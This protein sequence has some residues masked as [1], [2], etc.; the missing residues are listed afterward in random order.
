MIWFTS[1]QHFGHANIIKFCQR[2][3][4]STEEMREKLI[5]NFNSKVGKYD[6]TYHLGDM[7]W[8]KLQVDDCVNILKQLNGKHYY[9]LGN[10]EEVFNRSDSFKLCALFEGI[11]DVRMVNHEGKHIWA[12][13]YAHRSWPKSGHGS[14]HVFGHTHG[15][16]PDFGNSHDVGVDAN[17]YYPVSFEELDQLMVK[18]V[19]TDVV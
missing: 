7:F 6:L 16:L 2:P 17:N 18:K 10:H 8:R 15:A 13:H 5:D 9:I 19:G 4:A 3:F 14:Y 12:S 11:L 1:D